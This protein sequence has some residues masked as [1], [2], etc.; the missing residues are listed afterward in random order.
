MGSGLWVFGCS[1][2]HQGPLCYNTQSVTVHRRTLLCSP[3]AMRKH[4]PLP[5]RGEKEAIWCTNKKT[6]GPNSAHFIYNRLFRHLQKNSWTKKLITH[7]KN[8]RFQQRH[9]GNVWWLMFLTDIPHKAVTQKMEFFFLFFKY[10]GDF[11]HKWQGIHYICNNSRKN[12]KLEG[13]LKLLAN[14]E[15]WFAENRLEQFNTIF[16][17]KHALYILLQGQPLIL[18]VDQRIIIKHRRNIWPSNTVGRNQHISY[19]TNGA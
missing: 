9:F 19:T 8:S 4:S 6:D 17:Y 12:S 16:I 11:R 7:G 15:K 3:C 2:G 18:K 10:Q 14:P 13:K 5:C 1:A